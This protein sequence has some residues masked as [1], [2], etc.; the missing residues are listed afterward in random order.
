AF[1]HPLGKV[2]QAEIGKAYQASP[3]L[4]GF[5]QGYNTLD[6]LAALAFGIII[7]TTIRQRGVKN[8]KIIA[9]ETIKAGLISV[10]L[11]AII[12]TCLSY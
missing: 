4:T 1:T 3:I 5:T 9:K 11:M 10:G 7:I 12:Y 6:A 8:P 2:R